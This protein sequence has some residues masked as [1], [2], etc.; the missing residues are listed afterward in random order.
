MNGICQQQAIT[1][2]HDDIITMAC[3]QIPRGL[4]SADKGRRN[5]KK[6]ALRKRKFDD[7][8]SRGKHKG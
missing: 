1:R 3:K 8:V 7:A 4:V 6:S 5:S 2:N